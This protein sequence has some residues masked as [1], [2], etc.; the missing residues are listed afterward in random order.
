MF[1]RQ[2]S[3]RMDY[4]AERE[5]RHSFSGITQQTSVESTDSRLCYL[6]SS[7]VSEFTI[8]NS[9]RNI[10]NICKKFSSKNITFASNF[11]C[12]KICYTYIILNHSEFIKGMIKKNHLKHCG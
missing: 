3:A 6:T 5:A 8:K 9:N 11:K 10:R 1:E 12:L 4:M 2:D 7:E